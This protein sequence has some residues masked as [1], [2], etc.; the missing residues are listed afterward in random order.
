MAPCKIV[1]TIL[2]RDY[3]ESWLI[4]RHFDD[5]MSVKYRTFFGK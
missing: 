5:K 4:C 2:Q 3:K 1:V